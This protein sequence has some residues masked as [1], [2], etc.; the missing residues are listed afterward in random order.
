[1]IIF[2]TIIILLFIILL[3]IIHNGI[4]IYTRIMLTLAFSYTSQPIS[5]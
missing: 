2:L 3:N 1:M 4:Q 5:V